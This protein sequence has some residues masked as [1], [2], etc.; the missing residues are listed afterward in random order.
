MSKIF[1][2]KI[3]NNFETLNT[4]S[5][6]FLGVDPTAGVGHCNWSKFLKGVGPFYVNLLKMDLTLTKSD[7]W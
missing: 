7:G 2:A 3:V 1:V 4:L 5:C 6:I